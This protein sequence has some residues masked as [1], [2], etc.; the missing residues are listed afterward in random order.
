VLRS[1]GVDENGM[2]PMLALLDKRPKLPAGAFNEAFGRLVPDGEKAMGILRFLNMKDIGAGPADSVAK[3]VGM[4]PTQRSVEAVHKLQ[5]LQQGLERYGIA[6]WCEY[7][8][9]IVRGLAYY[10]GVVWEVLAEGERAVA[11][12]GRYDNLLEVLGGPAVGATG[13]GMGDLVLSILLTVKGLVPPEVLEPTLDYF[14]IDDGP[15]AVEKVMAVVGGLRERGVAADYSYK[16]QGVGK[17]LKAA[18]RRG[19]R[20]AIIVRSDGTAAVRDLATGEQVDRTIADVLDQE[21]RRADRR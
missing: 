19:A 6:D 20:K 15:D 16:R 5:K 17:Q 11:G 10:T 2:A 9:G 3:N 8:T 4:V 18:N 12:G 7:D 1:F 14:V 13:F 21:G